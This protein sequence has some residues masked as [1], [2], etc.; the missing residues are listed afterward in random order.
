MSKKPFVETDSEIILAAMAKGQR[1]RRKSVEEI[2]G[3]P[4]ARTLRAL[5][6]LFGQEKVD[7]EKMGDSVRSP[8]EWFLVQ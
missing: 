6:R 7:R 1:Y 4:Y 5:T 8:Y 3:L 2:T